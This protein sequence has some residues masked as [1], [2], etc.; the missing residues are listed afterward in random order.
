MVYFFEMVIEPKF[1]DEDEDKYIP[2][3]IFSIIKIGSSNKLDKRKKRLQESMPYNIVLL[4]L[5][6]GDNNKEKEIHS[7][8]HKH[9]IR[10]DRE[11]FYNH[12]DIINYIRLNRINKYIRKGEMRIMNNKALLM[13]GKVNHA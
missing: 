13:K 7:L 8:F 1:L 11:W 9:R 2:A 6:E 5:V 12:P 10:K 4:G 3:H